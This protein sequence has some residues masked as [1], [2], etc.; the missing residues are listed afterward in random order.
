MI[1]TIQAVL[2]SLLQFKNLNYDTWMESLSSGCSIV[3]LVLFPTFLYWLSNAEIMPDKSRFVV[4]PEARKLF[5][6]F[7]VSKKT[8]AL[9]VPLRKFFMSVIIVIFKESPTM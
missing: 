1:Y 6:N 3:V 5:D 8:F 7:K 4:D 9:M 2:F